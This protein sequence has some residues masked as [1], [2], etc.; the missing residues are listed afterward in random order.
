M[1]RFIL[2]CTLTVLAVATVAF[3][4]DVA[5]PIVNG[6]NIDL[7]ALLGHFISPTAQ[8][9]IFYAVFALY[10]AGNAILPFFDNVKFNGWEHMLFLA[11]KE[12]KADPATKTITYDTTALKDELTQF[13]EA[14]LTGV[15]AAPAVNIQ[16]IA[17]T[18]PAATASPV[19]PPAPSPVADTAA[20][21][22]P[23][24]AG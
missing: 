11:F 14:K 21:A 2:L 9:Y 16:P 4:A 8:A 22:A 7:T 18:D 24:P 23:I 20:P 13:I 15:T 3:G 17:V 10:V 19:I 12:L 6:S 1:K 5:A